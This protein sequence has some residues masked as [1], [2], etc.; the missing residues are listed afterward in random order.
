MFYD[1]LISFVSILKVQIL[2]VRVA[3]VI[4]VIGT[5]AE[6]TMLHA[7]YSQGLVVESVKYYVVSKLNYFGFRVP[8]VWT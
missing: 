2:L 8:G 4:Q 6:F 1:F 7:V 3:P 5:P